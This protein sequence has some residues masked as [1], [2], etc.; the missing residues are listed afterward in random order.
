[1]VVVVAI[2]DSVVK[3]LSIFSQNKLLMAVWQAW[4]RQ[5]NKAVAFILLYQV[6]NVTLM[7]K[8]T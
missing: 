8:P 4:N 3:K 6:L 2:L 7:Q 5:N 1:M